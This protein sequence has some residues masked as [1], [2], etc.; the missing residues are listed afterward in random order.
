[1]GIT[2]EEL[3]PYLAALD[4][5][6]PQTLPL[7]GQL[8]KPCHQSHRTFDI[9]KK[10]VVKLFDREVEQA[11]V[12]REVALLKSLSHIE[13]APSIRKWSIEERW[14]QEDYVEGSPESLRPGNTDEL[15]RTFRHDIGPRLVQIML[16]KRPVEDSISNYLDQNF[17]HLD[18]AR[19]KDDIHNNGLGEIDAF[20]DTMREK[21]LSSGSHSFC[22][23]FSHGDFCPANMLHTGT[24]L[25]IIDWEG[26]EYRSALFD[27]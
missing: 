11:V 16:F 24:G 25:K 14:Y 19:L 10:T 9:R 21:V 7:Y 17:R 23:A 18:D 1:M 5:A 2:S 4:G 13:F 22:R 8:C 12:A 20:V 26:V 6:S 15:L 27:F 3:E